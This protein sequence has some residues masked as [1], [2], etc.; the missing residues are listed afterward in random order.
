MRNTCPCWYDAIHGFNAF[1]ASST[2]NSRSLNKKSL[3]T[4]VSRL[5][6]QMS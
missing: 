5:H 2:G 4:F 1:N 3:L 6:L